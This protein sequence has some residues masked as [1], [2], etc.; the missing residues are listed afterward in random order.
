MSTSCQTPINVS[1]SGLSENHEAIINWVLA[2]IS[3][4]AAPLAILLNALVIIAVTQR[5]ELQKHSNI[6]LSSIALSDML[7]GIASIPAVTTKTL[8]AHQ[9]SSELICAI[10]REAMNLEGIFVT[11]SLYNLTVVAWERFVAVRKW[12]DYKVIVTKRRLFKISIIAWLSAIL[13]RL[14]LYIT[15][16]TSADTKVK[17]IWTTILNV[18]VIA[19]VVTIVYFYAM[20][21]HGVR[22]HRTSDVKNVNALAQARLESRVAK[23]T[24]LITAALLLTIAVSGILVMTM[25]LKFPTSRPT[26]AIEISRTLLRLN[27]V[28]NPVLYCFKDLRFRKAVLELLKI[29]KTQAAQKTGPNVQVREQKK[30]AFSLPGNV[31]QEL[32]NVKT[33]TRRRGSESRFSTKGFSGENALMLKR[34]HSAHGMQN[35]GLLQTIFDRIFTNVISQYYRVYATT[36]ATAIRAKQQLLKCITL[37]C[38]SVHRHCIKEEIIRRVLQKTC[39]GLEANFLHKWQKKSVLGSFLSSFRSFKDAPFMLT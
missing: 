3:W 7:T 5:K 36:K 21:Y 16:V 27:S 18:C 17:Y 1:A 6:L 20:I 25:R 38:P 23:T 2:T 26:L 29:R 22:N 33:R 37:F 32:K 4:I 15:V 39:L 12:M 14:P 30:S 8:I 10:N 28:F 24:A 9:S 34:S 11:C 13:T 31:Y 19:N 35:H